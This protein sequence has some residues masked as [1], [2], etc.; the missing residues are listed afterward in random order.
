M[1]L[2]FFATIIVQHNERSQDI[3]TLQNQ[4]LTSD[5]YMSML[6]PAAKTGKVF[7]PGE[8]S[9]SGLVGACRRASGGKR[10]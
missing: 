5:S 10:Q 1:S 9:G 6:S 2:G 8:A 7:G 3:R 4:S